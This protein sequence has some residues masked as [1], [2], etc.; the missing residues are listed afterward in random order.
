MPSSPNGADEGRALLEK[1]LL[2]NLLRDIQMFHELRLGC[3]DAVGVVDNP[4]ELHATEVEYRLV[5]VRPAPGRRD[6]LV[7]IHW[8]SR[9]GGLS[10]RGESRFVPIQPAAVSPLGFFANGLWNR[11]AVTPPVRRRVNAI[12]LR[13]KLTPCWHKRIERRRASVRRYPRRAP[14]L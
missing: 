8:K 9:P 7:P 12:Q 6:L 13:R 2:F 10:Y 4:T 5:T 3:K 14:N 11:L 1:H